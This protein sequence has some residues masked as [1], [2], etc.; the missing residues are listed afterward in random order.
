MDICEICD[1]KFRSLNLNHLRTHGIMSWDQYQEAVD[2]RTKPDQTLIRDVAHGLLHKQEVA[3]D[4]QIRLV[5]LQAAARTHGPAMDEAA[6]IRMRL[7]RINL[8]DDIQHIDGLLVDREKMAEYS[9]EQLV[10]LSKLYDGSIQKMTQL[11]MDKQ[12]SSPDNPTGGFG[13]VAGQ[14][15]NNQY[16]FVNAQGT[17]TQFDE[18]LPKDPRAETSLMQKVEQFLGHL[19]SGDQIIVQEEPVQPSTVPD[20]VVEVDQYA[21]SNPVQQPP[22][23]GHN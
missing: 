9:F 11:L 21:T 1:R 5:Q 3:E 2:R 18:A 10:E 15:V 23:D 14:I 17:P 13:E 16:N 7:R 22:P 12:K 4:L 8:M 19:R 6:A 20:S